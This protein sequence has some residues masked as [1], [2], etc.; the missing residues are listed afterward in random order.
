MRIFINLV[1]LIIVMN[2]LS[3]AM[4]KSTKQKENQKKVNDGVKQLLGVFSNMDK[5]L[6]DKFYQNLSKGKINKFEKFLQKTDLTGEINFRK[7]NEG[8][9]QIVIKLYQWM[10]KNNL[11]MNLYIFKTLKED[12]RNEI[13]SNM[14]NRDKR[15]IEKLLKEL[16]KNSEISLKNMN[17]VLKY[18]VVN[19][20]VNIMSDYNEEFLEAQKFIKDNMQQFNDLI[21]DTFG[22]DSLDS[23]NNFQLQEMQR[24]QTEFL[25]NQL[26]QLEIENFNRMAMEFA[27]NESM[28]AVL[29]FD[30]GG[31]LLGEGFNPSCT[32]MAESMNMMNDLNNMNMMNDFN[33]MNDLNNMNMMDNFDSMNHNHMGGM[34]GF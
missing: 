25:N 34:D 30:D 33:N 2:F 6:K 9:R 16:D 17:N 5:A 4:K 27:M 18:G 7:I 24:M 12:K 26:Q 13:L 29:P 1:F 14:K 8:I 11:E 31:Y 32:M 23:L 10:M 20:F 22:Y 3:K 28:K 21:H 15:I 19:K